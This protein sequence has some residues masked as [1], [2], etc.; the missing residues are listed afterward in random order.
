MT[1]E[2]KQGLFNCCGDMEA[3]KLNHLLKTCK[4]ITLPLL[5]INAEVV[6][7]AAANGG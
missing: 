7:L 1:Q 3:C 6:T 2:W 4:P 5:L